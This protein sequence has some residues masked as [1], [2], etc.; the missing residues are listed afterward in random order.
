[1]K[2]SGVEPFSRLVMDTSAFSHLRSG[3]REVLDY[4][5]A[6]EIIFFP[7]TALGELEAGFQL[8][9]RVREN[10]VALA[11]FL[12]E[13]FVSVAPTSAEVALRYG[14]VFSQL[15]RAGTPIPTN[16]IW[17]AATTIDCGGQL[18]T[19]DRHFTKVPGLRHTLVSV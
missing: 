4:V 1:M 5:A 10:R 9:G 17:I 3:H 16:N 8:G 18:L 14:E 2:K 13:P 19:F 6:A 11:D 15:K 12:A 7:V